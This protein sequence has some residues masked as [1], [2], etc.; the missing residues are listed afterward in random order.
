VDGTTY[1]VPIDTHPF[2][3]YYNTELAEQAGLLDEP[4]RTSSP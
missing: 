1:A 2:V 3:L 4:A